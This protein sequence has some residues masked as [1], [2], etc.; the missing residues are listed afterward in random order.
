MSWVDNILNS[1]ILVYLVIAIFILHI[2]LKKTG[3]TFMEFIEKIKEI[4]RGKE[5]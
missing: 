2:Y 4:F 5:E 3:Q 1:P